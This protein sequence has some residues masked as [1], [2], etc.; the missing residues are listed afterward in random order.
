LG[1]NLNANYGSLANLG[2][3]AETGKG[4]ATA[5]A[6]LAGNAASANF[7]NALMGIAG[8]GSNSLGA[9]ALSGG[10]NAMSGIGSMIFSDERV[11]DDMERVGRTDDGQPIYR[12][13][14]IDAPEKTHIGLS[15]Q[16]VEAKYPD[17]VRE[18]NGIKAVDYRKAT[19]FAAELA[20]FMKEAA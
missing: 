20:S 17:A 6:D 8:L 1:T 13:T 9:G 10:A 12:Y 11:K 19:D 16:E 18:F 5:N 2:Y 15:A 4:N 3:S 7:V 14:Y